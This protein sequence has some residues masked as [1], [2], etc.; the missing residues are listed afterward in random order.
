L[1]K[2]ARQMEDNEIPAHPLI[3]IKS[4]HDLVEEI[5]VFL[6]AEAKSQKLI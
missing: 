1:E 6:D 5:R 4:I 3:P 2:L